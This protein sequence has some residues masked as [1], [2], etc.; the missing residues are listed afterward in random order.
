MLGW[1]ILLLNVKYCY[2]TAFNMI[3]LLIGKICRLEDGG[4]CRK[5]YTQINKHTYTH[6]LAAHKMFPDL[7][8][9]MKH[10]YLSIC[11]SPW[12]RIYLQQVENV[13]P[14]LLLTNGYACTSYSK[15]SHFLGMNWALTAWKSKKWIA[16]GK[17]HEFQSCFLIL[18][19]HHHTLKVTRKTIVRCFFFLSSLKG[20][21]YYSTVSLT[22]KKKDISPLDKPQEKRKTFRRS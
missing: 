3:L 18:H 19:Y 9:I 20:F 8:F 14:K 5:T 16:Q 22:K 4:L 7:I 10:F 2:S 12:H 13:E 11:H 15:Y 21:Y 6:I 17:L 1:K